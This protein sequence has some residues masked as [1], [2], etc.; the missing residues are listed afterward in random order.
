MSQR[1]FSLSLIVGRSYL[2]NFEI[3]IVT[4]TSFEPGSI[5]LRADA[6]LLLQ[7]RRGQRVLLPARGFREKIIGKSYPWLVTSLGGANGYAPVCR[8]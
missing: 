2:V 7:P 3:K 4:L 1:K 5:A 8:A 6:L